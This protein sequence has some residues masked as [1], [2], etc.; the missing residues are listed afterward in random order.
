MTLKQIDKKFR[1]I[2]ANHQETQLKFIHSQIL[3]LI[4]EIESR[5][6]KGITNKMVDLFINMRGD[7]QEAKK[8]LKAK[9]DGFQEAISDVRATLDKIKK[10]L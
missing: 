1:E 5:L 4:E 9:N 10:E 6:P 8:Y 7:S 3:S 2:P